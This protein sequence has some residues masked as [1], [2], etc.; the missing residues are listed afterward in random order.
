MIDVDEALRRVLAATPS[1]GSET[2]P[3]AQAL[4]RVLATAACAAHALPSFTQSAVD[5][6]AVCQRDI[7]AAPLALP[8]M[9]HIAAMARDTTPVL[10]P[11]T[12]ARILTGGLLPQNADTVVRQERT[13]REEGHVHILEAVV[14]GTDVRRVG[15]EMAAGREIAAAGSLLTPGLIGALAVAGLVRVPVKRHPRVIVLV[16]GDEVAPLGAPLRLG[17]V[18][19]ANGP[20]VCAW[21]Q[22]WGIVPTRFAYLA[23]DPTAVRRELDCAL[24][25]ADLVLTTG[26]VSVGDHDYIPATAEA[27]GAERLLWKVAQKPGMPLFVAR[28]GRTLLFGLPGNP[29]SVLVNLM[30]YVRS[31]LDMMM[32]LSATARWQPAQAPHDLK[33]EAQKTFWLRAVLDH[34][35]DGQALLRPLRGQGSH[36][37]GNLAKANA[38]AR[39]PS[40][41][42]ATDA[43]TLLWVPLA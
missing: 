19:D 31:A 42:E 33:R 32:G 1:L 17:Q 14:R 35:R 36:M 37:L 5:G 9:Q 22:R 39:V 43:R 20:L 13:R 10:A 15:E 29:A 41:E 3:L 8:L 2:I 24:N 30:V 23:D 16:S 21:L 34:R 38:L 40:L 26:G 18:P 28:R 27:L 11:G 4:D 7:A 6:Y 12:A 25:E